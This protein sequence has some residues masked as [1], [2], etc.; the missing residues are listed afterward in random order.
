MTEREKVIKSIK[1]E[2]AMYDSFL[3]RAGEASDLAPVIQKRKQDAEAR[4]KAIQAPP[5]DVFEE[6]GPQIRARQE[7]ETQR[8]YGLIP[9]IS[10]MDVPYIT[11]QLGV[12][13]TSSVSEQMARIIRVDPNQAPWYSAFIEPLSDLMN[14]QERQNQILRSLKTLS[15][16]LGPYGEKALSTVR[17]ALGKVGT[18]DLACEHL[19]TAIQKIWGELVTQARSTGK[20]AVDKRFELRKPLHRREIAECLSTKYV[21]LG[22]LEEAL[23]TISYLYKEL[24]GP[25]KNPFHSDLEYLRDVSTRWKLQISNLL[26]VLGV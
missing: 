10:P 14:E 3:A 2:I 23:E 17:S 9:K 5:E 1:D 8:L 26:Q 13:G 25:A 20:I 16:N 11:S 12:T 4:L 18:V 24:S 19:R 6:I 21:D 7:R 22:Q 15:P